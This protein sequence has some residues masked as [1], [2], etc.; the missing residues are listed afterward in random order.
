MIKLWIVV[1]LLASH[2]VVHCNWIYKVKYNYDGNIQDYKSKL[3]QKGFQKHL[4]LTI[5]RHFHQ[6]SNLNP[7][8]QS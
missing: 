5:I 7:Y 8:A 4:K 1:N 2:Y 6:L 3:W